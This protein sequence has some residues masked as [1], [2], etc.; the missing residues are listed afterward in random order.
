M[1]RRSLYSS[2]GLEWRRAS[3]GQCGDGGPRRAKVNPDAVAL[4][5]AS[6]RFERLAFG[7]ETGQIGGVAAVSALWLWLEDKLD[8][9]RL[10]HAEGPTTLQGSRDI[11]GTGLLLNAI[12]PRYG[13]P[14]R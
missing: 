2:H 9:C 3:P 10:P 4:E 13:H 14:L 6:E 11:P 7:A 5:K 12:S 1:F 8:L